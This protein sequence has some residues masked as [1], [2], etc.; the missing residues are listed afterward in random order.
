MHIARDDYHFPSSQPEKVMKFLRRIIHILVISVVSSGLVGHAFAQYTPTISGVNAVWW[1]GTGIIGDGGLCSGKTT[2]CYYAKSQLMSNPNGAPGSPSWTVV[3]NGEG[4]ISL[5]CYNCANPVATAQSVSTACS[6][7]I[8]LKVSYGGYSSASF[9]MTVAAP[10]STTPQANYPYT[11]SVYQGFYTYFLWGVT[12]SCGGYILGGIDANETFG[13]FSNPTTNN[14]AY[15]NQNS[16]Y[17]ATYLIGDEVVQV[18]GTP[19][20]GTG[21]ELVRYDYPW[22][23]R[24]GSLTNGS[25][26]PVLVDTQAWYLNQGAH[27]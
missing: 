21:S 3:Q 15:P 23:L 25:G 26:T 18:G 13:T 17:M 12:S 27:Y 19:T 8:Q 7:D 20:P 1:L 24:I 5:S 6:Y 10:Q 22:V 16:V 4:K 9:G 2:A 14:W 11:D